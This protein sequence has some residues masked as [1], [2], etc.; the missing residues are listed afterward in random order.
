MEYYTGLGCTTKDLSAFTTCFGPLDSVDHDGV[1][2]VVAV[3]VA[4]SV[5]LVLLLL[6]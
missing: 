5:L 2:V 3:V 6:Y 1:A 4:A